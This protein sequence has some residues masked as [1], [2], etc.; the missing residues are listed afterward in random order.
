MTLISRLIH[1]TVLATLAVCAFFVGVAGCPGN[2]LT[3]T[4]TWPSSSLVHIINSGVPSAAVSAGI[5]G[6]NA[7]N[8]FYECF[9][10]TF[11]ADNNAGGEQINLSFVPLPTDP[12]TG[13]TERGVTHLS[14]A[15]IILGRMVEVSI[16][17]NN[18]MTVNSTIAEV[19]AHE[20]GH[21]QGLADCLSCGL[22]STVMESGDPALTINDSIGLTNPTACD[23]A[24]VLSVATDYACPPPPPGGCNGAADYTTYPATGCQSG[25]TNMGGT[26]TRSAQFQSRCAEPT[27]YDPASC[28]CPDGINPSP[29]VIDVS[30]TGFAMTDAV[31][32]VIFNILDDGVPL[33]ISWTAN[34]SSNAFLAL[35]R[36]GNGV[37]DSGAELF[38]DITP[39]PPTPKPNGFLALAEYDKPANGG[40]GDGRIDRRDAVFSQLKL[41]QDSNHNGISEPGELRPFSELLSAIALDYKE[42]RRTDQFGNQFRYRAKVF[43]L[44]GSQGGR[45]A[46]DVFLKVQQ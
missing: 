3:I 46:W 1:R 9:G 21:T 12:R 29:I 36:N 2:K 41:W 39:Q 10:P 6:W 4:Y 14:T 38:G 33:Q 11:I 42:A 15:V 40:N 20:L 37:I 7:M 44:N 24:L 45:W 19:L 28:T 5:A 16:D 8:G 43:D 32:G 23:I 17:L 31:G 25:F 30:S 22:H 35:D 34:R 13:S 26:C 18:Q 27:G